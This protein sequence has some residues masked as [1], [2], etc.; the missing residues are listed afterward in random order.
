[1]YPTDSKKVKFP[2]STYQRCW[3]LGRPLLHR[4]PSSGL[5][6]LCSSFSNLLK[7]SGKPFWMPLHS[8][9]GGA[10]S[11]SLWLWEKFLFF[12]SCSHLTQGMFWGHHPAE[13]CMVSHHPSSSLRRAWE[14]TESFSAILD[15]P[16]LRDQSPLSLSPS[17]GPVWSAIFNSSAWD[18]WRAW[19]SEA[20]ISCQ[21]PFASGWRLHRSSSLLAT[22]STV[23]YKS[24][25]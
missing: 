24:L 16:T 5:T 23:E 22:I 14:D 6:A 7:G 18:G 19:V 1:M 15:F 10:F 4:E 8:L 20:T 13:L 25:F 2:K 12:R 21:E 3:Y 17:P 9:L 11:G